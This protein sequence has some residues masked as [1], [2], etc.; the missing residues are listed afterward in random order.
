PSEETY[1]ELRA[2]LAHEPREEP[3]VTPRDEPRI[4]PLVPVDEPRIVILHE[5]KPTP[6]VEPRPV[7]R[8]VEP[9]ATNA[10]PNGDAGQR[11]ERPPP[12][13]RHPSSAAL[14]RRARPLTTGAG[15]APREPARDPQAS[16]PGGPGDA[17]HAAGRA[18]SAGGCVTLRPA[19]SRASDEERRPPDGGS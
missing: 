15:P 19:G 8:S 12:P 10:G 14:A 7:P 2:Q 1:E 11:A 5:T 9:A 4:V 13:P 16:S 6:R 18:E 3:K 17:P